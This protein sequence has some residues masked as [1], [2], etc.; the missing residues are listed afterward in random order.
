VTGPD[1]QKRETSCPQ[2]LHRMIGAI[3]HEHAV[4]ERN[5]VSV[6]KCQ[7]RRRLVKVPKVRVCCGRAKRRLRGQDGSAEGLRPATAANVSVRNG[8][9]RR[10]GAV[11][12][13]DPLR[14]INDRDSGY[15]RWRA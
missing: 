14:R 4:C 3:E 7:R 10:H 11:V 9:G 2:A 1:G 12:G 6:G 5:C 8:L 13:P 15:L